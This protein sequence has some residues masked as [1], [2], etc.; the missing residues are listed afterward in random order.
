MNLELLEKQE[1]TKPKTNKKREI[2]KIMVEINET[3]TKKNI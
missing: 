3:E 1:Q 2:I